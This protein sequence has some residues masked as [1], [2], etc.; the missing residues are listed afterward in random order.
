MS[1]R[2]PLDMTGAEISVAMHVGQLR[3][4]DSMNSGHAQK[5]GLGVAAPYAD[6]EFIGALGECAF[7]K[8]LGVYWDFSVRNFTTRDV[9]TIQVKATRWPQGK[10]ILNPDDPA[11]QRYVLALIL[12]RGRKV[13]LRGW[14]DGHD[15][16]QEAYWD[17]PDKYRPATHCVPQNALREIGDVTR[18]QGFALGGL[19]VV[20]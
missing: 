7:A 3:M 19:E 2:K 1:Q 20:R 11:D 10:L 14:I 15:A 5:R 12:E 6:I 17:K 9:G 18:T 4:I 8:H 13:T 16:K